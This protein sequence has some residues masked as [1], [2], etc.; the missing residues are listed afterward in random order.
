M[1]ENQSSDQED[2]TAS[3][4]EGSASSEEEVRQEPMK[5]ETDDSQEYFRS[6][7]RNMPIL[8]YTL[9]ALRSVIRNM[10]VL[11]YA[12]DEKGHIVAWECEHVTG[13]SEEEMVGNPRSFELLYPNPH[14]LEWVMNELRRCG[15]AY[16]NL[17]TDIIT[18]DGQTK[19]ISWSNI[20][21]KF[22]V[23]GWPSWVIGVD[24]TEHQRAVDA[25]KMSKEH[26]QFALEIADAYKL[27]VNLRTGAY[28]P[29]TRLYQRLG[30]DPEEYP[31]TMEDVGKYIHPDDV[32]MVMDAFDKHI[33]DKLSIFRS[34]YR[35]R[36]K[37]GDWVW[38]LTTGMVSQWDTEGKASRLIGLTMDITDR[39]E[40]EARLKEYADELKGKNMELSDITKELTGANK[41][42]MEADKMKDEFVSIL[43]HDLGTPI[44]IMK[45]NIEMLKMGIYGKLNEKQIKKTDDILRNAT[46]L[47]KLRKDTLD[48]SRIDVGSMTPDKEPVMLN[49]IISEAVVDIRKLADEKKQTVHMELPEF[50]MV[51]CDPGKVRRVLDNYLTNAVRYTPDGGEI[52]VSGSIETGDGN[53]LETVK[54]WVRDS[55]RGIVRENLEKVFERFF[56]TGER[57]AGSTGLGLSI[58]KGIVEIHGGRAWC[59]SKGEGK[60]STFYFTLPRK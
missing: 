14:Y 41:N 31:R 28:I 51:E 32:D 47:D 16:H 50:E 33:N 4:K 37:S 13:Y 24:I 6:V 60:G 46:R 15:D 18:K 49:P 25:L 26:L 40:T 1:P 57:V 38:F 52:M 3:G 44:A 5:K 2:S 54:I 35:Y 7:I 27:E 39:K 22:P 17:E 9:D 10:P 12:L 21:E 36:T 8:K 53:D 56:R 42:L 20:S 29:S 58:V 23:P 43:A 45:A 11:L 59:E 19:T 30:Y 55:G 34:E 48:L